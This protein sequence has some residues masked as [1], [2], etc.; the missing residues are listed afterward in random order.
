MRGTPRCG[1]TGT[2]WGVG[3]RCER[4]SE[5]PQARVAAVPGDVL[6]AAVPSLACTALGKLPCRVEGPRDES[7]DGGAVVST[8]GRV[9]DLV[10]GGSCSPPGFANFL[11]PRRD[12]FRINVDLRRMRFCEPLGLVGIAAF[13][14]QAARAG[15]RVVVQEPLDD[16]VGNFLSRMRLGNV[17]AGLGAEQG[18]PLVREH[19]VENALFEVNTFAG[20]RG[21]AALATLVYDTI[22]PSD[23]D[24]ALV[25]YDGLCEAGQNVAHHSGRRLGFLAAASTHGG[26][27]LYFAVSDSG[28]GML[29]TLR[30]RGARSDAEALKL[31][32]QKGTSGTSDRGRGVGLPDILDRVTE[33]GG[34]LHVLSGRASVTARG[35]RRWYGSA[36][37]GFEGTVLQGWV[38]RTA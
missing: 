21:A 11:R 35:P 37:H 28:K 33:L 19:V 6:S 34:D 29:S 3:F 5:G 17:L 32:L 27:R 22:E 26:R 14:E 16:N 36:D 1:G 38:Q 20:A 23:P 4:P 31:A 8:R 15:E 9:L 7:L 13:V 18:L 10:V 25:L 2:G 30:G 24:G 12:S